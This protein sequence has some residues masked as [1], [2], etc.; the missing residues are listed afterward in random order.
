MAVTDG[1]LYASD[2]LMKYRYLDV[3]RDQYPLKTTGLRMLKRDNSKV[4]K[5]GRG[6]RVYWAIRT[7]RNSGMGAFADGGLL[8]RAGK[9]IAA[10]GYTTLKNVAGTLQ[11]EDKLIEM[12]QSMGEASFR[13][14]LADEMKRCT[15]DFAANKNRMLYGDRTGILGKVAAVSDDGTYCTI[16]LDSTWAGRPVVLTQYFQIG[17]LLDV[18]NSSGVDVAAACTVTA[19]SDSAGTITVSGTGHDSIAATNIIT[20]VDAYASATAVEPNGF[21]NIYS[22]SDDNLFLDTGDHPIWKGYVRSTEEGPTETVMQFLRIQGLKKGAKYRGALTTFGVQAK[23]VTLVADQKRAMNTVDYKFGFAGAT[24]VEA[25]KG[26]DFAGIGPI[27]ADEDC[28]AGTAANSGYMFLIDPTAI[29][30]A[31]AGAPHWMKGDGAIMSRIQGY[32]LYEAA[33]IEYY[34]LWCEQRNVCVA[35]SNLQELSL[36]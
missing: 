33:F 20:K 30:F 26:P 18:L 22:A 12:S 36:E 13:D 25:L 23:M 4:T 28:P 3:F 21:R 17:D 32:A 35:H 15:I 2:V 7:G 24:D 16:T 11:I 5:D 29:K 10:T 27:I 14:A 34:D 8:P 19:V 9:Q 6:A 1:A 31:D